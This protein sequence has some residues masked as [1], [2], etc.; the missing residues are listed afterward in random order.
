MN[1]APMLEYYY[2][3]IL[4]EVQIMNYEGYFY[5]LRLDSTHSHKKN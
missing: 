4:E 3:R 1:P 2:A 5:T